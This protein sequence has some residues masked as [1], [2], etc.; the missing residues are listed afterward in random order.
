MLPSHLPADTLL[1]DGFHAA[2]LLLIAAF[3]SAFS[4]DKMPR[5]SWSTLLC[6]AALLMFRFFG[7]AADKMLILSTILRFLL[8]LLIRVIDMALRC[9]GFFFMST[10]AIRHARRCAR[11]M[12]FRACRF[13]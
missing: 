4:P 10:S 13:I 2:I 12:L 1:I 6:F 7:H 8:A 9:S 5:L 3:F 11:A